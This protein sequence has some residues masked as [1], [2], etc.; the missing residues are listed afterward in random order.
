MILLKE[1]LLVRFKIVFLLF[2]SLRLVNA[3]EHLVKMRGERQIQGKYSDMMFRK[4]HNT[5]DN[6]SE[7]EKVFVLVFETVFNPNTTGP[8]TL[9][10]NFCPEQEIQP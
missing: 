3:L 6:F 8:L 10:L 4:A 7:Q 9:P 2:F 1:L 5:S